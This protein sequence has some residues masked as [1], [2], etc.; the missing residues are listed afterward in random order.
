MEN[1]GTLLAYAASKG[2]EKIVNY[3]L[4]RR[5][6]VNNGIKVIYLVASS[7]LQ[8]S[9]QIYI[10]QTTSSR[11][12]SVNYLLHQDE[13]V[14]GGIKVICLVNGNNTIPFYLYFRQHQ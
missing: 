12:A 2:N 13:D 9:I 14:N 4:D 3:L 6:D 8:P 5:V 7:W 10:F 1:N 11:V